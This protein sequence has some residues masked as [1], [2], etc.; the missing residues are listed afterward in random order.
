MIGGSGTYSL[1]QY[2]ESANVSGLNNQGTAGANGFFSRRLGL[3]Q[4]VGIRYQFSKYVTHPNDSYTLTN[5]LSGFYTFYFT[6][7][8]SLSIQGGPEHYTAWGAATPSQGS[9]TPAVEASLGWQTLRTNVSA[10][11]SHIVSGAGGLIGTYQSDMASLNGRLALSRMWSVGANVGYSSFNNVNSSTVATYGTG[12]NTIFGG[13]HL[14]R[15]ITERVSAEA[16]YGH[17]YEDY[18]GIPSASTY[19]NSNRA[20]ISITYQ[21]N[22]PLGR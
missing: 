9:W 17:F 19:P 14:D 15:R 11:Y 3:S 4:Y 7:S 2:S 6:R 20:D 13:V 21:F 16:G 22:R 10:S 8:F 5:I 1:Q 18:P 12:G